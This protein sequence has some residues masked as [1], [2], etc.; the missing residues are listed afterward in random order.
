MLA[1]FMKHQQVTYLQNSPGIVLVV[2]NAAVAHPTHD[3]WVKSGIVGAGFACWADESL[4]GSLALVL[5]LDLVATLGTEV[6]PEST[7]CCGKNNNSNNHTCCDSSLVWARVLLA[8]IS[9]TRWS[10]NDR[11]A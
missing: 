11:F 7:S 8:I 6:E 4:D 5:L 2:C 10:N 3:C 9:I 1:E